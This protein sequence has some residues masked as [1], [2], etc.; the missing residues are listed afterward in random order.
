L[1]HSDGALRGSCKRNVRVGVG[2]VRRILID[3]D[4]ARFRCDRCDRHGEAW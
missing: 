4:V 3:A 1:L 2:S